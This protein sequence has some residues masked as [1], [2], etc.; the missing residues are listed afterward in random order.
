MLN[1]NERSLIEIP[2][3]TKNTEELYKEVLF[4]NKERESATK[5]E[6]LNML[7][8]LSYQ[9]ENSK[10]FENLVLKKK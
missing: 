8:L 3:I 5:I 4:G 2:R 9:L 7:K 10:C 1:N 6:L